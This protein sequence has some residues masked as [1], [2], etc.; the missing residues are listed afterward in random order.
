[1]KKVN[2]MRELV[3]DKI[4]ELRLREGGNFQA[5]T[6]RWE[7][8]YIVPNEGL[9]YLYSRKEKNRTAPT[10]VHLNDATREDFAVL[11]DLNLLKSY[12]MLVRQASKQM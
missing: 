8:Y 2:N 4:D 7:K 9:K 11:S 12:T 3:L 6:M 1:M 5:G 10:A